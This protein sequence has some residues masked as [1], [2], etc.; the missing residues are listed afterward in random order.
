MIYQWG[1]IMI[2][3]NFDQ[4]L[5]IREQ[6]KIHFQQTKT[7]HRWKNH[8]FIYRDIDKLVADV[9]PEAAE[10]TK[11]ITELYCLYHILNVSPSMQEKN[12]YK[13]FSSVREDLTYYTSKLALNFS[14]LFF[15]K[16]IFNISINQAY[17]GNKKPIHYLIWL[18]SFLDML[19]D[20]GQPLGLTQ[21]LLILNKIQNEE[22]MHHQ[23]KDKLLLSLDHSLSS[24][25]FIEYLAKKLNE[26]ANSAIDFRVFQSQHRSEEEKQNPKKID[27]NITALWSQQEE[28]TLQIHEP[29]TS[30][31]FA[32][33]DYITQYLQDIENILIN[34]INITNKKNFQIKQMRHVALISRE[35]INQDT[36]LYLEGLFEYEKT[37]EK[38]I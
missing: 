21:S 26:Q 2:K 18:F 15:D 35:Q 1:I 32:I 11:Q 14:E 16:T 23:F 9:T 31:V 25:Q 37:S 4:L 3:I 22:F 28:I 34:P 17:F 12:L 6:F 7:T 20:Q 38:E 13:L 27:L 8:P 33:Q 19:E 36:E 24:L 30:N 5:L 10:K 29:S